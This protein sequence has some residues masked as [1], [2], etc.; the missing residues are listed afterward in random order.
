[1]DTLENLKSF[2]T[3]TFPHLTE[4]TIEEMIKLC[5]KN[6]G[7]IYPPVAKP[8]FLFAFYRYY[9]ENQRAVAEQDYAVL[10]TVDLRRGPIVYIAAFVAP[11]KG[12]EI[13]RALIDVLNPLAITFHR[14]HK[15]TDEYRFGFLENYRFKPPEERK[16]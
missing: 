6:D 1:M 14:K 12:Y 5:L 3:E 8:D 7:L 13:F 4:G 2:V 15:H 16:W 11:I 9:P 10:D